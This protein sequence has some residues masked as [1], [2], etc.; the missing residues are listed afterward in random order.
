VPVRDGGC[1]PFG[2]V[3]GVNDAK[4]EERNDDPDLD[5]L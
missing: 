4:I 2:V 3:A 1:D 5:G